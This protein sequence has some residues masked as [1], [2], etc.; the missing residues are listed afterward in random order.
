MERSFEEQN[1]RNS[2]EFQNF[3]LTGEKKQTG[4]KN[5][6]LID[7]LYVKI[8]KQDEQ[9]VQDYY[10]NSSIE[11]GHMGN[12]RNSQKIGK[13]Y[14]NQGQNQNNRQE[15]N[16]KIV[17]QLDGTVNNI[18]NYDTNVSF[19]GSTNISQNQL[20]LSGDLETQ[21]T[22]RQ[23]NQ[24]KQKQK[25]IVND[26]KKQFNEYQNYNPYLDKFFKEYENYQREEQQLNKVDKIF[27]TEQSQYQNQQ[28]QQ[29]I[30]QNGEQHNQIELLQIQ[31]QNS[32]NQLEYDQNMQRYMNLL[33]KIQSQELSQKQNQKVKVM[34]K[35]YGNRKIQHNNP[36]KMEK[37]R[38]QQKQEEK[39]KEIEKNMYKFIETQNNIRFNNEN[40]DND[41]TQNKINSEE[42][43]QKQIQENQYKSQKK[44]KIYKE[45]QNQQLQNSILKQGQQY[46]NQNQNQTYFQVQVQ[47]FPQEK[48]V[49]F[50]IQNVKNKND[51]INNNNINLNSFSNRKKKFSIINEESMDLD[52]TVVQYNQ[53]SQKKLANNNNKGK[54]LEDL[55]E[56]QQ[57]Q[58]SQNQ[59][60]K[61]IDKN[62]RN[63]EDQKFLKRIQSEENSQE[64]SFSRSYLNWVKSDLNQIQNT[65]E[66]QEYKNSNFDMGKVQLY[67]MS[68]NNSQNLNS[69]NKNNNFNIQNQNLSSNSS[70]KQLNIGFEINTIRSQQMSPLSSLQ[71]SLRQNQF[72][73]N[74]LNQNQ[75]NKML[76]QKGNTLFYSADEKSERNNVKLSYQNNT[77]ANNNL[78]NNNR[79]KKILYLNDNSNLKTGKSEEKKKDDEFLIQDRQYSLNQSKEDHEKT[80]YLEDKGQ[81]KYK[82]QEVSEFTVDIQ[83]NDQ[84]QNIGSINNKIEINQEIQQDKNKIQD[85]DQSQNVSNFE[86][87]P[88]NLPSKILQVLEI[89]DKGNFLFKKSKF[90]QSVEQYQ[91]GLKIVQESQQDS[92]FINENE[93]LFILVEIKPKK[94]KVNFSN[95]LK[96]LE[97]IFLENLTV[98]YN[99][100][101]QYF[102]A[103]K[104]ANFALKLEEND[105]KAVYQRGIAYKN[106]NNFYAALK[107]FKD[108]QKIKPG[109][110]KVE[111][112]IDEIS[113]LI[114]K[115]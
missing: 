91:Y 69:N 25:N 18:Q 105:I 20:V 66:F 60:F 7:S 95:Y 113:Q 67:K 74:N 27:Y 97:L 11:C 41:S 37:I 103:L 87:K 101:G 79:I 75:N 16:I 99:K 80:E 86:L 45:K 63:L 98:C 8:E 47:E 56:Q 85:Q 2:Q 94:K 44:P 39:R 93:S 38:K 48:N 109:F 107:D 115:M 49:D 26:G 110:S 54:I 64:S 6:K 112:E 57:Q 4:D 51:N 46:Q 13:I 84:I 100:M 89:K 22:I 43:S 111:K 53:K 62:E 29:Q 34:N 65:S 21:E 70:S 77:T 83:K 50:N 61:Q 10:L 31:I 106:L 92:K 73:M 71:Q 104:Y 52:T 36:K 78:S 24:I 33:K 40:I 102:S 5:R 17:D 58:Q 55:N 42:N 35:I 30:E 90:S 1:R 23:Q 68:R 82:N 88:Q 28:N 76:S 9:G 32:Q 72:Q 59:F 19:Y 14:K 81:N 108:I 15:N 114:L 12:T 96:L 3:Y